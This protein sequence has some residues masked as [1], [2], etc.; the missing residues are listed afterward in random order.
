M[1]PAHVAGPHSNHHRLRPA[2][3]SSPLEVF[4]LQW[5]GGRRQAASNPQHP[6][7]VGLGARIAAKAC[8]GRS[9]R[10]AAE[11]SKHGVSR[12]FAQLPEASGESPAPPSTIS[13]IP[14]STRAQTFLGTRWL[15]LSAA[16]RHFSATCPSSPPPESPSS[17]GLF[18]APAAHLDHSTWA[19]TYPA[20]SDPA[21]SPAPGA[22]PPRR[23]PRCSSHSPPAPAHVPSPVSETCC[24]PPA[25]S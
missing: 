14:C 25:E 15:H 6:A 22:R 4:Y 3:P 10:T 24:P 7:R 13:P 8:P 5:L 12:L 19:I 11:C 17:K 2:I 23:R 21:I 16:G 20:E 1:L 9:R 18:S